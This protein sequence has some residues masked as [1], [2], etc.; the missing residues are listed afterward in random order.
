MHTITRFNTHAQ[1]LIGWLAIEQGLTVGHIFMQE[2]PEQRI[3]FLDAWTHPEHRRE[4]VHTSLW[5]IRWRYVT[6]QYNDW[7]V[8]AWCTPNTL[9]HLLSEGFHAGDVCTYVERKI[10]VE[11]GSPW[12]TVPITC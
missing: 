5:D 9:E 10:T 1:G 3:K 2:E 6:E 4:G 11:Q 12:P 8:Y 7:T